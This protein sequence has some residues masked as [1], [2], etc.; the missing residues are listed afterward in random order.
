M[1]GIAFVADPAASA[2]IIKRILT[3]HQHSNAHSEKPCSR[4]QMAGWGWKS[5]LQ[6]PAPLCFKDHLWVLVDGEIYG[7]GKSDCGPL[8]TPALPI[9]TALLHERPEDIYQLNGSFAAI[10]YNTRSEQLTLIADRLSSRLLF[11]WTDGPRIAVA[12]RQ[13][14]LLADSRVPRTLSSSG[15]METLVHQRTFA[16]H[17][18]Y[19][20]IKGLSGGEIVTIRNGRTTRQQIW[21]PTWTGDFNNPT[22]IVDELVDRTRAAVRRRI[23]ADGQP[24]LLLSG[25]LD[26]R[27]VLAAADKDAKRIHCATV[28][29]WENTETK[30]AQAVAEMAGAPFTMFKSVPEEFHTLLPEAS[31]LSDGLV[32]APL[33]L[34]RCFP[35]ISQG[36]NTI[37]SGHFLDIMFRGTYQPKVYIKLISGRAALP[38]HRSITDASPETISHEHHVQTEL[39]AHK[40]IL[41]TKGK[42]LLQEA[43]VEGVRAALALADFEDPY[44]AFD[45]FCL[46]AQGRH[47]TNSEFIALNSWSRYC[48]PALDR[49]LFD[50]YLQIPSQIR[51]K[52]EV[53]LR[54]MAALSPELFN[55]PDAGTGCPGTTGPHA[56]IAWA[57]GR[58]AMRR[59]LSF[60]RS[61]QKP[62][63]WLTEGS[64]VNWSTWFRQESHIRR[65]TESL[66][67]SP[68]LMELGLF[69]PANLRVAIASHMAG[70]INITKLLQQLL[71]ID[72]W[73]SEYPPS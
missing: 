49:D 53:A 3:P 10:A 17:T 5:G 58:A 27:M 68:R 48:I 42:S 21:R 61:P 22:K 66:P 16:N 37:F 63:P 57:L 6:G 30:V 70:Q 46:H 32:P 47:H 54:A 67:D 13:S 4:T 18:L 39:R 33:S 45:I 9:A 60:I 26:S 19:E 65:L 28:S 59:G 14:D 71:T 62:Q 40:N 15:L 50:L 1:S 51:V 12:S 73:L 20:G 7:D 11:F 31:R 25:G 69:D 44:D 64:W 24:G 56:R 72:S 29:A 34:L 43:A 8:N 52:Q 35:D 36:M 38:K 41:S 55:L 23:P 2:Q